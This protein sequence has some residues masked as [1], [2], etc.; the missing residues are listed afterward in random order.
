MVLLW[1]LALSKQQRNSVDWTRVCRRFAS[2]PTDYKVSQKIGVESLYSAQIR[3]DNFELALPEKYGEPA[4]EAE[5]IFYKVAT[6]RR[7]VCS[8]RGNLFVFTIRR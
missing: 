8:P 3:D 6:V 5:I 1:L 2:Y 4:N 7:K